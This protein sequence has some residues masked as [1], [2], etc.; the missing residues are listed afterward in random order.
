M[1]TPCLRQASITLIMPR[2][3]TSSTSSG[4]AVEE[5]GAVDEGEVM[6][7]VHALRRVRDRGRIANVA[8]DEF[9]VVL[10]LGEPARAAARI[11]V[12]HAHAAAGAQPA[13]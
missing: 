7:L 12:E 3:P 1:P 2:T 9:D 11:V 8:G 10:D 13:P 6:H 4:C 5:F